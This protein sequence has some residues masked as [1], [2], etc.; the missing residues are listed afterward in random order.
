MIESITRYKFTCDRCG[1]E[2]IVE[3]EYNRPL[4][5][6]SF[7]GALLFKRQELKGEV[8]DDCYK[9]FLELA[10]NFFDEVNKG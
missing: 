3:G 4:H 1:K 10:E 5:D 9:D 2:Q 8:C 6:V 7:L